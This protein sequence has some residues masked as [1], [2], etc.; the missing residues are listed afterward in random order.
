MDWLNQIANMHGPTFLGLYFLVC[1]F[2]LLACCL[3]RARDSSAALTPPDVPQHPDPYEVAYLRGGASEAL[4]LAILELIQRKYLEL[5]GG[6]SLQVRQ[7]EYPPP[8]EHLDE[9]LLFVFNLFAT[10]ARLDRVVGKRAILSQFEPYVVEY[11]QP[12]RDGRLLSDGSYNSLYLFCFGGSL[13]LVAGLG[14]YKL[15]AALQKG[16]HNVGFLILVGLVTLLLLLFTLKRPRL[17]VLGRR[18]LRQLQTAFAQT[19]PA[20]GALGN[21]DT[22]DPGLLLTVGVFGTAALAGTAF[23]D[24]HTAQLRARQYADS[25]SW[26]SSGGCSTGSSCGSSCGGGGCGGGGCGGC[27]G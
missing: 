24:L 17:T 5:E 12:A 10:P 7:S 16:K 14:L 21:R 27:G 2:A 9:R 11:E 1:L 15:G 23:A 6:A 4:Q 22:F 25:G 19:R 3:T 8:P 18:Y 20:P 13:M 26:S